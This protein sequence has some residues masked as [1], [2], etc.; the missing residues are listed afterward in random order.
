MCVPA[1][2]PLC[3]SAALPPLWRFSTTGGRLGASLM[4]VRGSGCTNAPSRKVAL[5]RRG[6]N[7]LVCKQ[8]RSCRVESKRYLKQKCSCRVESKRHR[9][10]K[11]SCRVESKRHRKQ[12]ARDPLCNN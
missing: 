6:C 8:K 12:K 11:C 3:L 10:Q 1:S 4:P 9:K 5:R 2:L 7:T